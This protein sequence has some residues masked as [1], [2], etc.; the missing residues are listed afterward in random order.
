MSRA[1][2]EAVTRRASTWVTVVGG[3][4]PATG[5]S[6]LYEPGGLRADVAPVQDLLDHEP[7]GNADQECHA[8]DLGQHHL[9]L[10]PRFLGRRCAM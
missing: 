6:N 2:T 3:D 4:R 1:R 8:E 5:P 9:A 7:D 10:L